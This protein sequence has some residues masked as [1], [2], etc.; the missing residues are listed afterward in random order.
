M[1]PKLE[2]MIDL[3]LFFYCFLSP[4]NTSDAPP[5]MVH[6]FNEQTLVPGPSVALRC[7][8]IGNPPPDIIWLLDNQPLV[9][10]PR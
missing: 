1:G 6:H 5:Q 10:H 9:N 8:A 3:L 7:S 2:D 4:F